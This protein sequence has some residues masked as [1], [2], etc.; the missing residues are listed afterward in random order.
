MTGLNCDAFLLFVFHKSPF[1]YGYQGNYGRAQQM[2]YFGA[3]GRFDEHQAEG[4]IAVIPKPTTR[5]M[6]MS[7]RIC[8]SNIKGVEP[9]TWKTIT[10]VFQAY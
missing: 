6:E 5:W 9:K 1:G 10:L 3:R 7:D 4:E 2:M 8:S